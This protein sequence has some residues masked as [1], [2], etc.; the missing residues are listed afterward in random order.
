MNKEAPTK[1]RETGR[2][3][4][5][6]VWIC[7]DDPILRLGFEQILSSE[8]DLCW[9]EEIP[10]GKPPS[11]AICAYGR[12]I[13]WDVGSLLRQVPGV[14]VLVFGLDI[15]PGLA[16]AG[17]RAGAGGYIHARMGA[18][19]IARALSLASGDHVVFPK[20]LLGDPE[21]APTDLVVLA[22]DQLALLKLVAAGLSR[23]QMVRRLNLTETTVEERLDAAR[24]VLGAPDWTGA[25]RACAGLLDG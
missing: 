13:D 17:M 25:A 2:K 22:S 1:C 16:G 8:A 5:G 14:P 10:P 21:Q 23:D 4:L 20:E 7:S 3:P 19:K 9:G 6:R 11:R 12:D 24:E 15:D 18:R